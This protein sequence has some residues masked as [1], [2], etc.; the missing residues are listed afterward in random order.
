MTGFKLVIDADALVYSIGYA[1]QKD[2]EFFDGSTFLA[3]D[4]QSAKRLIARQIAKVR[5]QVM[6]ALG[7]DALDSVE[8]VIT[9]SGNWRSAFYPEY[10]QYRKDLAKPQMYTQIR[11][12]LVDSMGASVID[13]MEADDY[14]AIKATEDV[15]VVMASF[16][17]DFHTVAGLFF[18]TTAAKL[19]DPNINETLCF[20]L[21]QA[22][23]G[24]RVDGYFGV[25]GWGETKVKR[26]LKEMSGGDR[27]IRQVYLTLKKRVKARNGLKAWREQFRV[28]LDLASLL[29]EN[30]EGTR[31]VGLRRIYLHRKLKFKYYLPYYDEKE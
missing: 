23:N 28:C 11:K 27:T 24:D 30:E 21:F 9:G 14:L 12:W 1:T 4:L 7:V 3:G 8:L 17:K 15:Q 16:D 20:L 18:H 19:Y 26:F 22:V 29:W 13:G 2:L 5:S 31:G 6:E 10:K 25:Y